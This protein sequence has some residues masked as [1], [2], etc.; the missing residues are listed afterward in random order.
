M[1][2]SMTTL[3]G[4]I[5][6]VTGAASGIGKETAMAFAREGASLVLCDVQGDGLAEIA[7]AA[8]DAGAIAAS[9]HKVDVADRDSM[10]AFAEE[11]HRAHESV[12]VLVNNAGVALG[13][14]FLD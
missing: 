14:G 2:T 4:K 12:D 10:R 3:P 1:E 6:L 8:R 13:G 7:R 5:V 9:T 11:V